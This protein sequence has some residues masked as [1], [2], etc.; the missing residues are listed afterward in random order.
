[1]FSQ[2]L[3]KT[4]ARSMRRFSVSLRDLKGLQPLVH[5]SYDERTGATND[6]VHQD[7]VEGDRL[8]RRFGAGVRH[9]WQVG[10]AVR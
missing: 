10:V 4:S 5:R 6:P 8:R 7:W 1:M 2:F 9:R 3:I